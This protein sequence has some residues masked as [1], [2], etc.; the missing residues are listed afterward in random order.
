METTEKEQKSK[1]LEDY[2]EIRKVQKVGEG[3]IAV[4]L[5]KA[6]IDDMK[7]TPEGKK[8][9]LLVARRPDDFLQIF[10]YSN[11]ASWS[12]YEHKKVRI[13]V[14]PGSEKDV[15][16]IRRMVV[17]FFLVGCTDIE[18]VVESSLDKV[19]T[20]GLKKGI[21]DLAGRKLERTEV[22]SDETMRNSDGKARDH[23]RGAVYRLHVTTP[24]KIDTFSNE[25][26][27][28]YIEADL[29]ISNTQLAFKELNEEAAENVFA[30]DDSCDKAYLKCLKLLKVSSTD[31]RW[32]NLLELKDPR[33]ILG[34][35]HIIKNF[36][37][38]SDNAARL[39]KELAEL[40]ELSSTEPEYVQIPNLLKDKL[41]QK[42]RKE[43]GGEENYFEEINSFFKLNREILLKSWG[44]FGQGP[45][46]EQYRLADSA[47]REVRDEDIGIDRQI[48]NLQKA[49]RK[50]KVR[51]GTEE[52]HVQ[53]VSSL[54]IMLDC[55]RRMADYAKGI[56]E[57]ALNLILWDKLI[58][59]KEDEWVAINYPM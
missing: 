23:E 16:S 34:F 15:E 54:V 29:S 25:L 24:N 38:I 32:M 47:I 11:P 9:E 40:L 58:A 30:S 56:S 53:I 55:L 43:D 10:P 21:E 46:E 57:I 2:W 28:M 42:F 48:R 14:K 35:R 3:T 13:C 20:A 26:K 27:K 41:K 12:R 31:V 8:T 6:W 1:S 37:R 36:E 33:A 50:W 44:S 59:A 18:V 17:G 51:P 5:P 45:K 22:E 19:Q 39:S 4:S 7:V 49:I 52:C